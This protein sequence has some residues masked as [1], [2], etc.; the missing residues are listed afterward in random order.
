MESWLVFQPHLFFKLAVE[1]E[2]TFFRIEHVKQSERSVRWITCFCQVTGCQVATKVYRV[3][4]MQ[5]ALGQALTAFISKPFVI[6]LKNKGY[7]NL[8]TL[9]SDSAARRSI[10]RHS[11]QSFSLCSMRLDEDAAVFDAGLLKCSTPKPG[12]RIAPITAVHDAPP[13]GS[14]P[15]VL[16]SSL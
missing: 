16:S 7:Y 12:P 10:G 15:S 5:S 4:T 8:I 13:R 14:H 2:I 1:K 3:G 11:A 9:G 6:P